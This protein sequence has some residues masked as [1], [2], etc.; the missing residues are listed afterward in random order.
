MRKII[1]LLVLSFALFS[2]L[3]SQNQPDSLYH[4]LNEIVVVRPKTVKEIVPVQELKGEELQRVNALS[5]AE[6]LKFFT[7]VQLK[8]YGGIGGVKTINVRSMG[9]EHLGVFYDGIEIGNA[10]NG[11]V[12]L[13]R[14]SLDNMESVS[15]YNGQKSNIF[16]SAKDFASASSVYMVTKSPQFAT[17]RKTNLR[18]GFKTGAFD[19]VNPTITWEQQISDKLSSSFNAEYT[20]SSGKY[21]FT[22]SKF[23]NLNGVTG[24]DTTAL[25]R[26]GDIEI[27]RLEQALYGKL[28][29]G[30]WKTRFYFY[31][32]QRGYPGSV[33]KGVFQYEDRQKDNNFFFQSSV[34]K[35]LSKVY[36]SMLSAKYAYD[37]VYYESGDQTYKNTY[38]LHDVYASSSNM[39][40]IAP[41]CTANVAIDYQYN[42]M[43]ADITEFIYPIRHSVWAVASTSLYW[44][45]IKVQPS[46]LYNYTHEQIYKDTD[47]NDESTGI[48]ITTRHYTKNDY[49]QFTSSFVASWQPIEN[50]NLYIRAFYKKTFRMPTFSEMYMTYMG[51]LSS[52]LK[53]E[54][55]KQYNLGISYSKN[56]TNKWGVELQADAY[57]NHIKNKLMAIG[58]GSNFRWTILN[59]GLVKIK[60][61]DIS[62]ATSYTVNNDLKVT[63]KFNYTYQD[64]KDYTPMQVQSDSI[65]YKGQIP[66]IPWNSG[67]S[68]LNISYKGWDLNYSFVYTGK[69]YTSSA[70]ISTNKMEAWH[71]QDV[72]VSKMF[73]T[74][75]MLWY[76][77]VEINNLFNQK[78]EIISRYPMPGTNCRFS[79]RLTI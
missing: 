47:V 57:H 5:V 75:K 56:I 54:N 36:S 38:K 10:Q 72:W 73:K 35:R 22:Y 6:A 51:S 65:S 63:A 1:S 25:R 68:I 12:D 77:S 27:A 43:D 32:S 9:S 31:H 33:I 24:Y 67:T 26:N 21:K 37:Y 28:E 48:N 61:L 29:E 8:D 71:T 7:G 70:N 64:A 40:N 16:Q 45:R 18:F 15:L 74:R 39:F 69:R 34:K 76:T 13:G 50:E 62:A 19:L 3:K 41:F 20:K 17:E 46:L 49:K 79:I 4:N 11:V 23:N 52:F 60:G 59:K 2:F 14:Y 78:Y 55:A 44:S 66:Y 30:E 42:K 53:P 58:G